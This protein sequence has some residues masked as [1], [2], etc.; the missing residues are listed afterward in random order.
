MMMCLLFLPLSF[1]SRRRPVWPR[2]RCRRGPTRHVRRVDRNLV[3]TDYQ[4]TSGLL[5]LVTPTSAVVMGRLA[6]AR[7][8]SGKYV[9]FVWP[10]LMVWPS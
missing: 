4:S 5:D 10:L 3:V 8:P 9:R 1:S 2:W 7:V 6:I